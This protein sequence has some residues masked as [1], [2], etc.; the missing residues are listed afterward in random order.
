MKKKTNPELVDVS[1]E[2]LLSLQQQ[3]AEE[4]ERLRAQRL[5]V[6]QDIDLARRRARAQELVRR[7]NEADPTLLQEIVVE[8]QTVQGLSIVGGE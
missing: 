7:F 6:A 5:K 8:A 3:L 2:D 1:L 4:H